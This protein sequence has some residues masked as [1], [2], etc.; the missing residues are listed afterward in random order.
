M[1]RSLL[2]LVTAA[3]GAQSA[4]P[5]AE[6][7][8]RLGALDV[9]KAPA[10]ATRASVHAAT[11][12]LGAKPDATTSWWF[13]ELRAKAAASTDPEA[14]AFLGSQLLL[15]PSVATVSPSGSAPVS[16][17]PYAL[18]PKQ[19][20]MARLVD[21]QRSL[22]MG[23]RPSL[24]PAELAAAARTK[25]DPAL[26]DRALLLLRRVDPAMAAPLLWERLADAKARSAALRWEEE[27]QRVPL[28]DIGRGFPSTPPASWS[29]PARAA[30]L[31][32]IAVRAS[33]R[34][35]KETV[36][37]LLKGPADEQ[38]EAAWDAVPVVFSKADLPRL[39]AAA[40]GLSERL[41][42]RARQALERLR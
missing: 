17:A 12:A 33:L 25:E 36:L 38:T 39:E 29:K 26:A 24:R 37:G 10:P 9:A 8:A 20:P 2:L 42:P 40:Q 23:E 28:A 4:P 5:R 19:G 1:L 35:D 27:L 15:D 22:E 31:R 18:D 41:A 34:A 21:S 32:V 7:E 3:L 30:W 11:L 14:R 6:L 13:A 16:P